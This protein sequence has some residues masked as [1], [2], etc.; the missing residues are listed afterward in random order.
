MI[1]QCFVRTM[2]VRSCALHTQRVCFRNTVF[3]SRHYYVNHHPKRLCSPQDSC[4]ILIS[5]ICRMTGAVGHP[6]SVVHNDLCQK[7]RGAESEAEVIQIVSL[8]ERS[9]SKEVSLTALRTIASLSFKSRQNASLFSPNLEISREALTERLCELCPEMDAR[10]VTSLC[11]GLGKLRWKACPG[12]AEVLDYQVQQVIHDVNPVGVG[13]IYWSLTQLSKAWDY[14]FS[15]FPDISQHIESIS[16]ELGPRDVAHILWSSAL[17]SKISEESVNPSTVASLVT[18]L[19]QLCSKMNHMDIGMILWALGKLHRLNVHKQLNIARDMM[20]PRLRGLIEKRILKVQSDLTNRNISD[21]I[22][23]LGALEYSKDIRAVD[24]LCR[25]ALRAIPHMNISECLALLDG[26]VNLQKE[27]H[28]ALMVKLHDRL[29]KLFDTRNGRH[30]SNAV[31]SNIVWFLANARMLPPRNIR[32]ECE[33]R[34]RSQSIL[35]DDINFTSFCWGC[36]QLGISLEEAT[37]IGHRVLKENQNDDQHETALATAVWI[38]AMANPFDLDHSQAILE[39]AIEKVMKSPLNNARLSAAL[40]QLNMAVDLNIGGFHGNSPD[41]VDLSSW[42]RT[43]CGETLRQD[44]EETFS[45]LHPQ[46]ET[47]Q[48][49]L[50][51]RVRNIIRKVLPDSQMEAN[52]GVKGCSYSGDALC[53]RLNLVIEIEGPNH[54]LLKRCG[55]TKS[56]VYCP[57][58]NTSFKYACIRKNCNL[59]T[60]PFYEWEKLTSK[61]DQTEYIQDLVSQYM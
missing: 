38:I 37:G 14:R 61:N 30:F 16:S 21:A 2:F 4:R 55:E 5:P 28:P 17:L 44:I 59:V 51:K 25:Q 29:S 23:G 49:K 9:L 39:I 6:K 22:F 35:N 26:M 13:K 19:E 52:L 57:T 56:A 31:L 45:N 7:I 27:F 47:S 48:S 18:R 34:I 15:C 10:E 41:I 3:R 32:K 40:H 12:L 20:T 50:E 43:R 1:R 36:V 33:F 46:Y 54:F 8:K 11:H 42:I 53:T 58:V 60:V 24:V